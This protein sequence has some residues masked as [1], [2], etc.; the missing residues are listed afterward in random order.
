MEYCSVQENFTE[1]FVDNSRV[2][3]ENT[4][5][6][7]RNK[8][9][10][11]HFDSLRIVRTGCVPALSPS[12]AFAFCSTCSYVSCRLA[13]GEPVMRTLERTLVAG[14]IVFLSVLTAFNRGYSQTKSSPAQAAV[15]SGTP[16][17]SVVPS[18]PRIW[19]QQNQPL[20][21]QHLA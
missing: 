4:P 21:V 14:I 2:A 16:Q 18:G 15:S 8:R 3:E 9:R 10:P 17:V 6:F 7:L 12:R 19:L 20:P 1:F 11:V 13:E 5:S